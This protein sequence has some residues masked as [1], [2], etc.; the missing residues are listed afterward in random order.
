MFLKE[1]KFSLNFLERKNNSMNGIQLYIIV[2]KACDEV[3]QKI[4]FI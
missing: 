4:D 3:F 1:H 2:S